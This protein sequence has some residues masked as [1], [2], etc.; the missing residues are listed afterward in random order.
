MFNRL[1][2]VIAIAYGFC[3]LLSV[4]SAA[5]GADE[6][7]GARPY[8]ME[9]ADRDRD[10]RLPNVDFEAVEGWT[11]E[12]HDALACFERSREQQLWGRYAGKLTY[13][14]DGRKPAVTVRPAQPL[15]VPAEWDC[16]NLWVYG[17]N[18]AF[19][20]DR[21]TPTVSLNLLFRS[22]AGSPLRINMGTVRWKEW[23]LM[24]WRLTPEQ[25]A[26]MGEGATWEGLEVTGGRNREDRVLYFDNLCFY[27]ES[28]PPL[29]F[30]PRPRRG[31]EPFP[32]QGVG[33]N[34][35]PGRLP[36]PNRPETILPDNLT[37]RFEVSVQKD[38]ETYAFVYQGD[39]GRLI[40]RYR[41]VSGSLGDVTAERTHE[42][43]VSLGIGVCR[44][45][46]GIFPE[47][48]FADVVANDTAS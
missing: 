5:F 25:A 45:V 15:P 38:G 9:W 37:D 8:E 42:D 6:T 26:A 13:R 7:V 17:N 2:P 39:D 12:F 30:D 23:W 10:T 4:N 28:L 1:C 3:S 43:R 20:P 35:G 21:S 44:N 32:G 19:S 16:V 11:V 24:H 41:P 29:T 40:Y 36:F 22:A 27:R 48:W 14:A 31:I 33:T 47:Y 18:W 34:T 46:F